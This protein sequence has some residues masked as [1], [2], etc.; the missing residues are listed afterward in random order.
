MKTVSARS[1][2]ATQFDDDTLVP[3]ELIGRLHRATETTILDLMAKFTARERANLAVFCYHRS[4]LRRI[5]LAIAATC[6]LPALVQQWG[7]VLGQAVFAQSRGCAP[8]PYPVRIQHRPKITL[9][10][11]AGA[12][13]PPLIDID[14]VPLPA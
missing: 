7:T 1:Q 5:G 4:H 11:S 13:R 8:E 10:H 12:G 14:D 2:A 3:E 6:D 9:A